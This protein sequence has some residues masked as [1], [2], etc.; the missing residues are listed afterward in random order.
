M[1]LTFTDILP[2]GFAS[3]LKLDGDHWLWTGW[4]NDVGYPYVRYD[5]RDQPAY[6]VIWQ[7]LRGPIPDGMELDHTCVTPPCCNPDHLEVVTHAENVLR[8]RHRQMACRKA[9]H[10]WTDPRNV[11]VRKSGARY[12]AECDRESC[13]RRY[14]NRNRAA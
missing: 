12:C 1:S 4:H 7:L 5:G 3:R 10:D 8:I 9:G 11:R 2:A 13:R 14:H 6:R